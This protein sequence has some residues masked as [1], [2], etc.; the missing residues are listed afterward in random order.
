MFFCIRQVISSYLDLMNTAK[1][2]VKAVI[3]SSEKLSKK[4][5][6]LVKDAVVKLAGEGKTVSH[7]V[8]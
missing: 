8:H 1:G 4:T 5:L 3:I 6:D 7:A 2:V